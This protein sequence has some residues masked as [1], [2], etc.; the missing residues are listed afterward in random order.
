MNLLK[1]F[2]NSISDTKLSNSISPAGLTHLGNGMDRAAFRIDVGKYRGKIL[3]IVRDNKK[4]HI[5]QNEYEIRMWKNVE[6]TEYEKYFCPIILEAS[7]LKSYKYVVMREAKTNVPTNERKNL[8][9][10]YN[11]PQFT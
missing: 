2:D 10:N 1:L 9:K 3:K 8:L 7:D 6:N 5:Q 11:N 4:L